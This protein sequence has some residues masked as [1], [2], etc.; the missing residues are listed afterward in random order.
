MNIVV[1]DETCSCFTQNEKTMSKSGYCYSS[2]TKEQLKC[3]PFPTG[4]ITLE[5]ATNNCGYNESSVSLKATQSILLLLLLLFLN[6]AN[7]YG[8]STDEKKA[9]LLDIGAT[10]IMKEVEIKPLS[11]IQDKINELKQL[12]FCRENED[13]TYPIPEKS[14]LFYKN[15]K[16]QYITTNRH[17]AFQNSSKKIKRTTE[18][19]YTTI[20]TLEN[21]YD[22]SGLQVNDKKT[23][24]LDCVLNVGFYKYSYLSEKCPDIIEQNMFPFSTIPT[25]EYNMYVRYRGSTRVYSVINRVT[26]WDIIGYDADVDISTRF[27]PGIYLFA[28]FVLFLL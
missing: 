2:Y 12:S 27:S 13:A 16:N 5:Y 1:I 22:T 24:V 26:S 10:M 6:I 8:Y 25:N 14:I 17:Y 21:D 28:V 20:T 15:D 19:D 3:D 11:E 18:N 4:F 23:T 9:Y 7:C